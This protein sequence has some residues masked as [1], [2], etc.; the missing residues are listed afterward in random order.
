MNRLAVLPGDFKLAVDHGGV[1][2]QPI[3][4][5]A[6]RVVKRATRSSRQREQ[7]AG[8]KGLIPLAKIVEADLGLSLVA[9]PLLQPFLGPQMTKQPVSKPASWHAADLLLDSAHEARGA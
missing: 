5:A 7:L 1:K 8:V 2:L 9:Q 6:L 4:P 3:R